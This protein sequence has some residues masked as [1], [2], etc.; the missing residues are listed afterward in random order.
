MSCRQTQGWT[1]GPWSTVLFSLP[2]CSCPLIRAAIPDKKP[3][4]N[5]LGMLSLFVTSISEAVNAQRV[6]LPL[7]LRVKR[8]CEERLVF[9]SARLIS[10][11]LLELLLKRGRLALSSA[12][13]FQFSCTT[14]FQLC[15]FFEPWGMKQPTVAGK[16]GAPFQFVQ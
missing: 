7:R 10:L 12:G 9:E 11:V 2:S 3:D 16:S 14:C 4:R 15:L 1:G 8:R 6:T 13:R 5:P